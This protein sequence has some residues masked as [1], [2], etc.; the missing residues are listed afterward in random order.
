MTETILGTAV[1]GC[2]R[3]SRSHLAAVNSHPDLAKLVAVVDADA[4]LAQRAA[5]EYGAE[6]AA[7][8][9][10]EVLARND[11]HAVVICLPNDLHAP[12]AIAAARAGKHVLVEKPMATSAADA[13]AMAEAAEAAKITLAVA[14]CRRHFRAIQAL[15]ERRAEFGDLISIQVSLGVKWHE[16]QADWW[17]DPVRADSLVIA[18]NGPHVLDF[19]HMMM[20][21]LPL[22]VHAESVRKQEFWGGEDEAMILL[23]YPG[24]RIASVHLSFN[25]D[26]LEDRKVLVFEKGTAVLERDRKLLFN[27]QV[28]VEPGP[29]EGRHYLDEA[30][31]FSRQFQ[32][33]VH[34]IRNQPN[35]SV[36]PEEG[37]RVMLTLE[38]ALTAH[39]TQHVIN[40]AAHE[41]VSSAGNIQPKRKTA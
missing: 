15:D 24:K 33:F 37:V 17:R 7:S 12:V 9:V 41:Q 20:K 29:E 23:A 38:A 25:Q 10:D 26:P 36:L 34:A 4:N 1:I 31:E 32:E 22:R 2:G 35:R 16:A 14:Q 6:I 39:K 27:D 8:T 18:L 5:S 3:I 11:V 40:V 28:L 13:V 30:V 21:D 19:V